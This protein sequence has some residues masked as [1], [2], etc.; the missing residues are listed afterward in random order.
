VKFVV[1]AGLIA[2]ASCCELAAADVNKERPNIVFLLAD[3]QRY[4]E[5]GYTG[6]PIV[7]TPHIDQLAREGILFENS[8]ATSPVCM[9]NR[10]NL[11]TGQWERRHTI[12]WSGRNALSLEQWQNT[13]PVVLRRNGYV[14]AYVGKNHTPGLRPWDF[15]YYYGVAYG[16]LGFYPKKEFPI[17]KNAAADTQ[18][19]ILGEGVGNFLETDRSFVVRAGEEAEVFLKARPK[20]KPFFLYVC[21]NVPHGG[22][23]SKME[24]LP[25]DDV[26]YRTAYRQG[27]DQIAPPAGYI[28][29]RDVTQ[30]KLPP[31]I[32][33]GEQIDQYDY[34]KGV[35]TLREQRVRIA[36]TVSG[37]DR[38]V[39]EIHAQ[40]E[41]SGL[42]GNTIIIYSSD[43]GIL[44]GEH[45]YGGK[46]LLYEPSIRVPLIIYDPR[47]PADRR[48]IVLPQLVGSPDVAPTILEMCGVK[49]P[50]TMQGQSLLP[51]LKGEDVK[52][53][54]DIFCEN[55]LQLQD[56]PLMQSVR[57]A[58]WKY[59]RYWPNRPDSPDYRE[60]LNMGLK[61]EAPAYEEL[62][63]LKSDPLEQHNLAANPEYA[64]R[65]TEMRRRCSELLRETRGDPSSLPA[66][67]QDDWLA[68][69]PDAWK[70]L[71]PA[72]SLK[73]SGL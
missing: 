2:L 62:F 10:T 19:E 14:T 54:Q 66:I 27:M 44:H 13:F 11:L 22:G 40:L 58:E 17:F 63:D 3:D 18:V 61:G 12:N 6:D 50:D 36:Q 26:L 59:I 68:D 70:E 28:G 57:S 24:Q 73:K 1:A 31:E 20:N 64:G 46:C 43:N 67:G 9:P 47:L 38:V 55:M 33:S 29:E 71:L 7:K 32:Y 37:I 5:L 51:L 42:A 25:S 72:M 45:G 15:D 35:E 56:Y 8:F 65:L 30:A 53:R 52:W 39:G 49:P 69:V 60:L 34:V 4:D 23:T 48:G 41:A 16:H 21:F